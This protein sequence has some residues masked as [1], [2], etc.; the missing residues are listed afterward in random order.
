MSFSRDRAPVPMTSPSESSGPLIQSLQRGMRILELVAQAEAGLGLG[1]LA[2]RMDLGK[3]TVHNLARTLIAT[4]HLAQ[5]RQPTRYVLG[6]ALF[7]LAG[8]QRTQALH[9]RAAPVL[10]AL[11]EEFPGSVALLAESAGV[12]VRVT[13]RAG[14]GN[15]GVVERPLD[16]FSPPYANATSLLFLAH[17]DEQ[18]RR[19]FEAR[20][21]FWELGAHLWPDERALEDYLQQVRAEGYAAPELAQ[22]S[23]V[24]PIAAPV[25][26]ERGELVA[27]LGLAYRSDK[28]PTAAVK[29]RLIERVLTAARSLA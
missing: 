9:E 12:E 8:R 29:R 18:E 3:T 28:K 17:R 11:S 25:F 22:P 4:G 21:P 1:E 7:E 14:G 24:L 6:P 15:P 10:L 2:R 5:R 16:R 26:S 23:G 13:L 19:V 20:H 27:A